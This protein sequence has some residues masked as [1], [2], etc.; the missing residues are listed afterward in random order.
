MAVAQRQFI[1]A[2]SRLI[3]TYFISIV[4]NYFKR[5]ICEPKTEQEE[6]IIVNLYISE[7]NVH[8][9]E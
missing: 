8:L 6:R 1:C 5:Y 3:L 9:S 7:T 2:L 4:N